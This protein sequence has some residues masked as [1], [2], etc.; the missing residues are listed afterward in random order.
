MQHSRLMIE[1]RFIAIIDIK[2]TR[3]SAF[4]LKPFIVDFFGYF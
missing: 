3:I 2:G 4:D 1:R